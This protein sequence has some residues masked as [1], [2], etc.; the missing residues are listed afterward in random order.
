ML[1][2]DNSR[3]L[4][5]PFSLLLFF[6]I[7]FLSNFS[8]K[9]EARTYNPEIKSHTLHQLSQPEAAIFSFKVNHRGAWVAQSVKH[10][11]L[12]FSSGHDLTVR[13]I[14]PHVRLCTDSAEPAWNSLSLL[15]SLPLPHS[16]S[17]ALSLSL[18]K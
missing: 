1:P 13:G 6:K 9:R 8:T 15:L 16:C 18:S 3:T 2:H 7:L 4:F 5:D 14:K 17:L 12:D 11:S 10:L